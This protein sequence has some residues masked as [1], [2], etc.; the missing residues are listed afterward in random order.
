MKNTSLNSIGT[1]LTVPLLGLVAFLSGC[2]QEESCP[3]LGACGGPDPVGSWELAPGYPSCSED[4]YLPPSDLR[5]AQGNKTPALVSPPEPAVFD[6]CDELIASGSDKVVLHDPLFFYEINNIGQ[7]VVS[8]NPDGTFTAGLTRVGTYLM[9][10]PA[11]CVRSFGA[12]DGK[13]INPDDPTSPTG[14][15]CKQME[16]FINISGTNS[17]AYFNTIC[18][19]NPQ[20]PQGCLC[21]FDASSTGG[22]AGEWIR[23][24]SNTL[25]LLTTNA[26]PAYVTFCNKGSELELT[27]TDGDYLFGVKGLRTFKLKA[28]PGAATP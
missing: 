18:D 2:K 27:G 24:D 4:L 14:S 21:Q 22:P 23:Y 10:F 26:V 5:L 6:W 28:L 3:A 16:R 25:Q 13:V 17:G 8:I 11:V 1:A 9:D 20:D 19:V 15:V 7:A 12:Q